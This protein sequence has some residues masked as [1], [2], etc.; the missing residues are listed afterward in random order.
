L[1]EIFCG[2]VGEVVEAR[3][4]GAGLSPRQRVHLGEC[5]AC[6]AEVALVEVFAHEPPAGRLDVA[7]VVRRLERGRTWSWRPG[8]WR[9]GPWGVALWGLAAAATL[10][11]AVGLPL[12]PIPPALPDPEVWSGLR[13]ADLVAVAE[14]SSVRWV[15][16]PRASWYEVHLVAATGEVERVWRGRGVTMAVPPAVLARC[17]GAARFDLVVRALDPQGRRVGESVLP[18]PCR[19]EAAGAT[20]R[21]AP[22]RPDQGPAVQEPPAS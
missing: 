19:P 17:A 1:A 5:P 16:S 8:L 15:A 10:A 3:L 9:P 18:W 20:T 2:E 12:L 7:W 6:A 13:S 4:E 11:L 21:L 22:A 14:G